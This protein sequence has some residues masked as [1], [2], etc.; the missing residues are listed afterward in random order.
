MY[1]SLRGP[2]FQSLYR[3]CVFVIVCFI[4]K[5]VFIVLFKKC[6]Q[7][8]FGL[9]LSGIGNGGYVMFFLLIYDT[10]L[11]SFLFFLTYLNPCILRLSRFCTCQIFDELVIKVRVVIFY[12]IYV[13]SFNLNKIIPFNRLCTIKTF[14][15]LQKSWR[16][17]LEN[18]LTCTAQESGKFLKWIK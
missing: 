4:K 5:S 13:K 15:H 10:I 17:T 1:F 7:F 18:L 16:T 9:N 3:H 2:S 12:L 11:L 6:F 14:L 8:I